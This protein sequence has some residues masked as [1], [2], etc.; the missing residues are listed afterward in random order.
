MPKIRSKE[1]AIRQVSRCAAILKK[2]LVEKYGEDFD[3][4]QIGRG[5]LKAILGKHGVRF[6][7]VVM[8]CVKKFGIRRFIDP[9]AEIMVIVLD[10]K[11][12]LF[13]VKKIG[14][15]KK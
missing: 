4:R 13:Q 15:R 2:A 7:D 3:G 12:P 10:E 9:E 1:E 5:D 8:G 14:G 6:K 11:K